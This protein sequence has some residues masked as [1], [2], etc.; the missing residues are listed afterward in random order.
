LNKLRELFWLMI[1]G[2]KCC[3]CHNAFLEDDRFEVMRHGDGTGEP[4]SMK[5]TIHHWNGLHSDNRPGNHRLAHSS[6]HKAHHA[7]T[8]PRG[9]G[10]F[11]SKK[12]I[13]KCNPKNSHR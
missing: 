9:G 2:K 10:K 12:G 11:I 1:R 3:F 13:S 5:I 6:C 8:H 4:L 7:K